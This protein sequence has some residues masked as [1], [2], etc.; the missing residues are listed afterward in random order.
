MNDLINS[1]LQKNK[2]L[3]ISIGLFLGSFGIG[4]LVWKTFNYYKRKKLSHHEAEKFINE[5][6]ELFKEGLDSKNKLDEVEEKDTS[7]EIKQQE[8]K[9]EEKKEEKEQKEEIK[10]EIK[11]EFYDEKLMNDL[12][13]KIR[14]IIVFSIMREM[15]YMELN[16]E[17]ILD[18]IQFKSEGKLSFKH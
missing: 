8:I 2:K 7:T 17:K 5:N 6:K 14:N 16:K 3:Y 13:K 11:E 12:L 18:K 1:T 10:T 15:K 9:V 4:Y